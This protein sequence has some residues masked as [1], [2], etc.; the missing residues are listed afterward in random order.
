MNVKVKKRENVT[1]LIISQNILKKATFLATLFRVFFFFHPQLNLQWSIQPNLES[2]FIARSQL[3]PSIQSNLLS[4]CWVTHGHTINTPIERLLLPSDMNPH[5]TKIQSPKLQDYRSMPLHP[6]YI[7]S[8]ENTKLN[9]IN[10][11]EII[12]SQINKIS[13]I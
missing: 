12:H 9:K 5:R 10:K 11:Q 3:S 6:T 8:I 13:L 1:T 7:M 4:S 2:R